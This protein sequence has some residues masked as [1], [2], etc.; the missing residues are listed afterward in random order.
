MDQKKIEDRAW[1]KAMER[2]G[3]P[4]HIQHDP[5]EIRAR[6]EAERGTRIKAINKKNG[7]DYN[8][9]FREKLPEQW[10]EGTRTTLREISQDSRSIAEG[11]LAFYGIELRR[12]EEAE[13]ERA[14][15]RERQ[16]RPQE[17]EIER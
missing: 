15:A 2:E 7:I 17:P 12:E 8:L 14:A 4:G 9:Q 11:F 5:L 13:T 16:E 3:L 10:K 1:Q 6:E